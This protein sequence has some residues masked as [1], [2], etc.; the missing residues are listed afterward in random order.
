MFRKFRALLQ[1]KQFESEMEL[2]FRH[3]REAFV[4]DQVSRG[5]PRQDAEQQ[6]ISQFGSALQ[7]K[8]ECRDARGLYWFDAILRDLRYATR[9]LSRN[10]VFAAT[11]IVTL[12]LCIGA[13][14]AIYSVVDAVLFRPLPYPEP[15][16]LALLSTL[17]RGR[18][19]EF[20]ETGQR[21]STWLAIRQASRALDPAVFTDI[22]SGVNLVSSSGAHNVKQ[23]RVSAGFFRVLGVPPL[24]GREF[25]E[26][27][28]LPRGPALAIL[29]NSLWR[30]AFNA[31]PAVVGQEITLR[32]EP[33]TVIGVMPAGF[34]TSVP[35]DLWTPL[36]PTTTGEGSGE[37]YAIVARLK[38]GVSWAQAN[39]EIASFSPGIVAAWKWPPG[40][41]ASLHLVSMQD[42]LAID[43]RKS[44]LILWSAVA[45]VL[46][47]GCVNIAGLLLARSGSRSKEIATRMALGSGR[48]A[49][50]RQLLS[51]S[52]IIASAGGLA[53]TAL[54]YV[55][56]QGLKIYAQE[57]F[58][59]WQVLALD[60]RVLAATAVSAI[61]ASLIF[62]LYPAFAASRVDLRSGLSTS[63]RNST[64]THRSWSRR[65]LIV[66]EVALG[67]VLLVS[68]GLL[69]RTLSG[70][71]NL[72][73]GFDGDHAVAATL[74]LQDARYSSAPAV[75][76]L[77]DASL[78]RIGKIPGVESAAICLTL[79]YQRALNEGF[80]RLDG[81]HA[82]SGGTINLTYI[83][84]HYFDVFRIPVSRGR[85]F[86]S[87][88]R[89][90]TQQVVIV[91]ESF[92]R[93]YMNGQEVLGSHIKTEG[94]A[95]EIVGI[96]G[97]VQ[98]RVQGWP[99]AAF[100]GIY[101]PATQVSGGFFQVV[102]TWFSP[103]WVVRS[104]L[105][106]GQLT[107]PLQSAMAAID[108]QLP[109]AGFHTMNDLHEDS[110]AS[111]RL[112]TTLLGTLAALALMLSALGIYGL[113][114]SSVA[115]R[116]REFGIRLALGSP[117]P[118]AV[119]EIAMPGV[120]LAGIGL[121]IGCALTR[122][123]AKLLKSMIWGVEP[124]DPLSFAAAIAALLLVAL[125]ASVLPSLRVAKIN[126]A[127]TLR[128]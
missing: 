42:G 34:Q 10:R 15:N 30:S 125:L 116:T 91:N 81:P 84:P 95:R 25:T 112:E 94:I 32:G 55:A 17:R 88:D 93:K 36:R 49:I 111:Q 29:S 67:V 107:G 53:G 51:E 100:P 5:I 96:V 46:L 62:G 120:L 97:D 7:M 117:V 118:R 26:S 33:F 122:A 101:V 39:A 114:A 77:F 28:D 22:G 86:A 82:G 87:S 104:S 9:Q 50:I 54:G 20:E 127:E 89:A 48:G 99:N 79:P 105:P 76:R 78:D 80:S 69:I 115:E 98:V 71:T 3:H 31:D 18:A 121:L 16:R 109:F 128:E 14:T 124:G 110:L 44:I 59:V 27:E 58:G 68:A 12:A 45:I 113:I 74:S 57:T 38:S 61:M 119:R 102:H 64:I 21:G 72:R 63:G 56:L 106:M 123:A 11:A 23:Q 6:A 43:L 75:T 70:L 8:D 60:P 126:P 108:P 85:T 13:N 65:F 24:M 37:N 1:R 66:V 103:S 4:E 47:I 73:P 41:S 2:E 83:T 35:A 90:E 52:L 92:V 40:Q 19:A